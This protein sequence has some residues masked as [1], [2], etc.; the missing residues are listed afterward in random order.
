MF[1]KQ[2]SKKKYHSEN[3]QFKSKSWIL[4]K[5]DRAKKQGKNTATDSKYSGR[6][7]PAKF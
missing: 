7:R 4:A 3:G 1:T 2:I 6:K 5:K